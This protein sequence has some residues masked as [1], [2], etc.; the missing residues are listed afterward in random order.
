MANIHNIAL[1]EQKVNEVREI[2]SSSQG[3]VLLD[4]RGLT[5][6]EVTAL[7]SNFRK[8]DVHYEVIK[9]KIVERAAEQLGLNDLIPHL[10]GPS[11]LAF[12]AKDPVAPAKIIVDFIK[13]NKKT[14]IKAGIV[15]GKIVDVKSVEALAELPSREV[16][17]AKMMGSM[18]APITGLAT[19][20]SGTLRSVLYALNALKDSKEA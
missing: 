2:L 19:V 15:N 4:Y 8:A 12:G 6:K 16:L 17:L 11:A 1:K 13:Q 18:N 7:R 20:L 10:K 14:Q 9:N 5:V 3:V